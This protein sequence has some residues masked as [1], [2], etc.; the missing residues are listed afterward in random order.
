MEVIRFDFD[1]GSNS[2]RIFALHDEDAPRLIA[3]ISLADEN[4]DTIDALATR[5]GRLVLGSAESAAKRPILRDWSFG[6]E[7]DEPKLQRIRD[8]EERAANGNADALF[9]VFCI[10]LDVGLRSRDKSCLSRAE[11]YL[12]K[13]TD[14]GSKKAMDYVRE[15]W[16]RLRQ[17]FLARVGEEWLK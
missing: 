16:P 13:A 6:M 7:L 3:E 1:H 15:Q 17:L 12:A 8:L 2:L 5:L 9:D 4:A 14:A 10:Y 11:Q